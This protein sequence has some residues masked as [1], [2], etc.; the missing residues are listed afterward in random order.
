M[1]G[2]RVFLGALRY[3]SNTVR[4]QFSSP[5]V[6]AVWS[7]FFHSAIAFLTQDP[8]Q[9]NAFSLAKRSKIISR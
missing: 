3:F 5:F 2:C 1:P 8:L 9:L 6:Y 7:R 4:D